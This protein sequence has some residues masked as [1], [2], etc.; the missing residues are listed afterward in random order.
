MLSAWR[1]RVNSSINHDK[2]LRRATLFALS[3]LVFFF[4]WHAKTAVYSGGGP[5]KASPSTA[6][7]LWLSSEK[8]GLPSVESS[9]PP[10]I[11]SIV[12]CLWVV[13]V[14]R[15]RLDGPA[16]LTPPTSNRTLC[17]LHLFLRPPPVLA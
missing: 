14:R 6:A 2:T 10:L 12:L 9:T 17:D 1:P 16:Y 5:V 11:A 4:A 7:K 15:E 13:C 8:L 3:A